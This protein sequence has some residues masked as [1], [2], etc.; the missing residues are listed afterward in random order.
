MTS[1]PREPPV[2]PSGDEARDWL[3]EELA[4]PDYHERSL[5]EEVL[6][7][8]VRTFSD[9][10]ERAG[11]IPP[12]SIAA[13]VLAFFALVVAVL[14]LLSRARRDRARRA[15]DRAV[16]TEEVVTAAELRRR[17]EAA[18]AGGRHDDALVD[19]FRALTL[20]QQEDGRLQPTPGATAHEIAAELGRSFPSLAGRLDS[21]A[22]A[23]EEVRYGQLPAGADRVDAVLALD[24]ELARTRPAEALA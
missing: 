20:R 21:S 16:L 22:R 3:R 1:V 5:F 23:F 2:R 7:W 4:H 15:T 9:G 12:V 13:A 8:L 10:V 11:E 6:D 24:D 14:L 19:G 17:A 18:R